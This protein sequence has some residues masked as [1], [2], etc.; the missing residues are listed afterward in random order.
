[1]YQSRIWNG[2]L[3]SEIEFEQYTKDRFKPKKENKPK[4]EKKQTYKIINY[5]ERKRGR[6]SKKD[7]QIREFIDRMN[8]KI[9][10]KRIGNIIKKYL[11]KKKQTKITI[12]RNNYFTNLNNN[13]KKLNINNKVIIN[14]TEGL[15]LFDLDQFIQILCNIIQK[16]INNRKITL[17]I[18]DQ[19]YALNDTTLLRLQ[20]II[21]NQVV[22]ENEMTQSDDDLIYKIQNF[23]TITLSVFNETHK[24][25]KQSGS[26]FPYYNT[27]QFDLQNYQIFR[28]N[29]ESDYKDTCLVF[30]LKQGGLSEEKCEKIKS[31]IKNRIIPI[32]SLESICQSLQIKIILKKDDT[33]RNLDRKIFGKEYEETY[34]IG[35]LENHYFIIENTN[36]TSFSVKN[37][38]KIKHIKNYRHIYKLS[39]KSYKFDKNRT[40]DSFTL[41]KTM[42]MNRKTEFAT[43][44]NEI[45]EKNNLINISKNIWSY[46]EEPNNMFV[47]IT[48][49]NSFIASTQFYDNIT[50]SFDSLE[51]GQNN[52]KDIEVDENIN[53]AINIFFDFETITNEDI[54]IPY[55]ASIIINEEKYSFTGKDVGL[56]MLNFILSP[57]RKNIRLIAHNVT[58][59][60][61]FLIQYLTQIKILERG[62]KLISATGYYEYM[63]I[64]IK[65]SLSLITMPLKNFPKTF[66]LEGKKEIMPYELYTIE[67][68]EKRYISVNETLQY[69]KDE[70]IMEFKYN[71]K[72]WNLLKKDNTY[73]I[74]EYSRIYC[75]MDC[76]IL[77]KGYNTFKTWIK[78]ELNLD[79]DHILTSASLAHRFFVNEHCY[80]EVKQISGIPQMFIQ[81]S[82]VGGRVMCNNNEKIIVNCEKDNQINDFDAVSLYPSAMNRLNGFLIG[83]PKIIKENEKNYT[84]LQKQDGYFIEIKIK[85]VNKN[86]HF[87]L[88]SYKNE[89]NVRIFTNEMIDKNLIVDKT[90]LEDLIKFQQIEFDVIKGYYF[91]EGFNIKINE[92]ITYLFNKRLE[93]KKNHNPAEIVYKL[94][95]NSGYGKSIMKPIESETRIFDDDNRF[96]TYLSRNY[97]WIKTWNKFGNNK[98]KVKTVKAINEHFNIPHVGSNI[99]SMSKRIMN[100]VMCLAEDLNIFIYYQ[101]TDSMHL[102]DNDIKTLS[103]KFEKKY[104]RQ[105]IGKNLGQFH[106][107]FSLTNCIDVKAIRSIFLGKKCYIDELEGINKKTNKIEKGNH[108]R[109]KGIPTNCVILKAKEQEISPF[110]LYKKLYN[111]ETLEFDLTI[112]KINFKYNNDY[113]VT[114]QTNFKR[115]IKY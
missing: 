98:T 15:K 36:Y 59:D 65:D 80:D 22:Q 88:M 105:L 92:T 27:T 108:I 94:I 71:L 52:V 104:D 93:L 68:I 63:K 110:E 17:K 111:S 61:R 85:K 56:Q 54:H 1:M 101:D 24:Y 82:V 33:N 50:P 55:L 45:L 31:F 95:M 89:E 60:F 103:D 49:Q 58:Y 96:D 84:F 12:A 6:P 64:Q 23:D 115:N 32:S 7:V 86:R 102:K 90:S 5:P 2:K 46:L 19:Y 109:M 16:N 39:G 4:K 9:I 43:V 67:N 29:L 28:S 10:K 74:I 77:Q 20:K 47:P 112:G 70:D 83:S 11:N 26:F 30:A 34:N 51:Y 48:F 44:V 72:N 75:E 35:L 41:I 3:I 113:T 14:N 79:I 37:Y 42:M 69:I 38:E 81:Q 53:D 40:I 57:N 78:T 76:E 73:D 8:E 13:I 18:G 66:N 114:T 25:K 87:P 106:S 97:N 99:L 62:N 107:D 91:N 100:E 21:T